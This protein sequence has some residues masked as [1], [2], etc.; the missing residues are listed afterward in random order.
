M[1]V[2]IIETWKLALIGLSV[3]AYEMLTVP[4]PCPKEYLEYS[5]AVLLFEYCEITPSGLG[6]TWSLKE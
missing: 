2:A 3:V 5:N 1:I 6:Y 4:P